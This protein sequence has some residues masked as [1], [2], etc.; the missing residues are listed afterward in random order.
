MLGTIPQALYMMNSPIVTQRTQAKP[1]TVLG[2]ILKSAPNDRAALGALYVRV[3]SRQPTPKE[4]ETCARYMGSVGN[5]AEVFED[6]Y[7]CLI[8]STEFITRR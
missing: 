8:N 5:R 2:E 3:L 7:W 1:G 4:V 6:I